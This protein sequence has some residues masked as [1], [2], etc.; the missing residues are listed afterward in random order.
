[1]SA[2]HH[3]PVHCALKESFE[4]APNRSIMHASVA[5]V[6]NNTQGCSGQRLS[7]K[8]QCLLPA[9][10]L[11]HF[12][13]LWDIAHLFCKFLNCAQNKLIDL[14][15]WGCVFPSPLSTDTGLA[16]CRCH[17]WVFKVEHSSCSDVPL[18]LVADKILLAFY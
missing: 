9:M 2:S 5:L 13:M 6:V 15:A 4:I 17:T 1:M 18:M 10:C 14:R 12:L 8:W 7:N 3:P 16:V 11:L